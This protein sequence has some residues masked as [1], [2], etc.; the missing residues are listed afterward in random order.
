MKLCVIGLGYIGLP[1]AIIFALHGVKVHGVDINKNV[2]DTL[3]KG[4]L[5]IKEP[6]LKEK[7][8]KVIRNGAL[9]VSTVPEEADAFIISVPT[10]LTENKKVDLSY[11]ES[12][13]NA[14]LPFLKKGNL[15]ILEST[16]PPGTVE[17]TLVT[18][19]EKSTL[20]IGEELFVSH[21]PE[22]VL[23][24]KLLQELVDNDR[25]V[26]GINEESAQK[27]VSLY[28]HF[29]KGNIYVTDVRTAELVKLIENTYRDVNIALANELA[30]VCE[31][32]DINVW[33]A[34]KLANFHPRVNIHSPGPGVGGHCIAVDPWFLIEQSPKE[35]KLLLLSRTINSS[36][37]YRIVELIE[38]VVKHIEKPTIT[39]LGLSY[40]KNI[41]D[42]RESPSLIIYE[43]LLEKNYNVKL[44]DPYVKKRFKE[45]VESIELAIDKTDCLVIL[46]DHD[47]YSRIPFNQ[48]KNRFKTKNIIDTRYIIDVNSLVEDGFACYQ[49]GTS[50]LPDPK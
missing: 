36:V 6:G 33:E 3:Q 25:V 4:E 11:V 1:T 42:I 2:I 35:A 27:T 47:E 18:L 16:V 20:K 29:V 8:V 9:T 13:T 40:K 28:K 49:I 12:A 21:S 19:L 34:I 50:H 38:R 30:V 31:K 43:Q 22:R 17:N 23:P 39:L 45:Q 15:V 41:D 37:P 14:I 48:L 44:H 24:G 5:H 10:P 26:G 46:A 32:L 7:L